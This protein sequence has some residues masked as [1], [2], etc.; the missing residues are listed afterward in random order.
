MTC[1]KI[2]VLIYQYTELNTSETSMVKEHIQTCLSCKNLLEQVNQQQMLI[3]QAATFPIEVTNASRLTHKIMSAIQPK[4]K[5]SWW[6]LFVNG[7]VWVPRLA[8]S[9][10]ASL[11]VVF[12]AVEFF[13]DN[14]PSTHYSKINKGTSTLNTSRFLST[15][16]KRKETMSAS[17]SFYNCIKRDDCAFKKI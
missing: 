4:P 13:K 6:S 16:W 9:V 2:E 3:R 1:S 5:A 11:L 8:M 17:F 15:Q 12:F 14:V 7:D 10:A